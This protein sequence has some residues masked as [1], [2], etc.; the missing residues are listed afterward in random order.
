MATTSTG[1]A[2]SA[3][4]SGPSRAKKK[5]TVTVR[6]TKLQLPEKVS[7]RILQRMAQIAEAGDDARMSDMV[8]AL[9][10][11]LAPEEMEK[12]WDIDV[13]AGNGTLDELQKLFAEVIDKTFTATGITAGESKSSA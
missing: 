9:E 5:T 3:A 11:I 2:A 13:P 12:V 8:E 1:R 6:G 7:L 10:L 4:P